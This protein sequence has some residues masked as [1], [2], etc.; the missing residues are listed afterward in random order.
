M[1]PVVAAA[2]APNSQP[3]PEHAVMTGTP[4]MHTPAAGSNNSSNSSSSTGHEPSWQ[5]LWGKLF[6]G[7]TCMERLADN[8]HGAAC[9]A[10][11]AS[12]AA[13]VGPTAA[14]AELGAAQEASSAAPK[15]HW[16]P[17]PEE[18]AV[19]CYSFYHACCIHRSSSPHVELFS[20][21]LTGQLPE[22]LMFDQQQMLQRVAAG[23]Q[24]LCGA[25]TRIGKGGPVCTD[26]CD[27]GEG[28]LPREQ[29]AAGLRG[30]EGGES[31]LQ[32]GA[33]GS[34]SFSE[35]DWHAALKFLFPGKT[36]D[37]LAQLLQRS[38]RVDGTCQAG[39][40]G[41]LGSMDSSIREVVG[42]RGITGVAGRVDMSG[43][44]ACLSNHLKVLPTEGSSSSRAGSSCR[45][46]WDGFVC[47]LL[48]QH[49]QTAKEQQEAAL[50]QLQQLVPERTQGAA[51]T[52][53]SS[54][55]FGA[56][57]SSGAAAAHD[58]TFKQHGVGHQDPAWEVGEVLADALGK[59]LSQLAGQGRSKEQRNAGSSAGSVAAGGRDSSSMS[60]LAAAAAARRTSR[61]GGGEMGLEAGGGVP[62]QSS[63][64]GRQPGWGLG[65]AS[66]NN[67]IERQGSSVLNQ[68]A[69]FEAGRGLEADMLFGHRLQRLAAVARACGSAA[70]AAVGAVEDG[71]Q[72]G[73]RQLVQW[74]RRE[75][76]LLPVAF[77]AGGAD[78]EG[79]RQWSQLARLTSH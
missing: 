62:R 40:E 51:T 41:A 75:L 46:R 31:S 30:G 9:L 67:R 76:L 32:N 68:G 25:R 71:L 78:V 24:H 33:E 28:A 66:R 38:C 8:L 58:G 50:Q 37:Q 1:S 34:W 52:T 22:E 49:L 10:D 65:R 44:L 15:P 45:K 27:A 42:D 11:S 48:Q 53:S 39:F 43:L 72:E 73:L 29:P 5:Q 7:L 79:L 26:A 14:G 23:V 64:S 69:G 19:A 47:L 20:E 4:T 6:P 63:N 16:K 17:S 57:C 18:A 12:A 35:K 70:A 61:E 54:P 56:S 3:S 59:M 55:A 13:A 77:V 21:V 36:Q 74:C 2:Q 60:L